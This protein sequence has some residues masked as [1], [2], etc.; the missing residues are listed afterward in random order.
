MEEKRCYTCKG[1][2]NSY[3]THDLQTRFSNGVQQY[4]CGVC[5]DGANDALAK[6]RDYYG[7]DAKAWNIVLRRFK[8]KNGIPILGRL[9]AMQCEMI[10]KKRK[11]LLRLMFWQDI[12]AV[13]RWL[14]K[15]NN[16]NVW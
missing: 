5:A 6:S 11:S 3:D 10:D 7:I 12:R 2:L 4:L 14:L 13:K 15:F 1:L 9:T 8:R 16:N